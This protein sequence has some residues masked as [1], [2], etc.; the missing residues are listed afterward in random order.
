VCEHAPVLRA[1]VVSLVLGLGTPVAADPPDEALPYD[2]AIELPLTAAG[3][4]AYVLSDT[5]FKAD[6]A[7]ATCGW[8]D[9][10]GVDDSVRDALVWDD[11]HAAGSAS[12][13]TAFVGVP[14][15][16]LGAMAFERRSGE[17]RALVID[18]LVVFEA[19]TIA[20]DLNQV[21]KL[22]VGRERPFVHQLPDDEKGGTEN[23]PDNNLSFYSGHTGWS[24]AFATAAGTIASRRGYKSAPIVWAAGLTLAA[25]SGYLRI[26]ADKHYLTDVLTGAATG[27]AIGWAVPALLHPARR[28][29]SV[30]VV[31]APN[32]VAVV[33]T[34]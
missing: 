8:C 30:E 24:F 11:P 4:V 25:T 29:A 27:A 15:V 14:L 34:Y 33:G 31:P 16:T 28:R 12:N 3:I 7:P 5:I 32:G 13:W 23:P 1:T 22:T 10:P 21:V 19:V 17:T 20:T 2:P 26:A 18:A 6:L 9:P